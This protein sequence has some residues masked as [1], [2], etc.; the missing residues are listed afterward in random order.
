VKKL[1]FLTLLLSALF[2]QG[3]AE[4]KEYTYRDFQVSRE[5][6]Y[7]TMVGLLNEEGYEV[8][9]QS[10]NW[11]NDLPE[12]QMTTGWNMNQSGGIYKGND[13]RRKAYIR[14]ITS[15]TDRSGPEFQPLNEKDAAKHRKMTEDMK[16]RAKLEVTRVGVAVRMERRSDISRPFE[17][18]WIYEGPDGTSVTALLGKFELRVTDA[19]SEFGPS[20]KSE[21]LHE[22]E[23]RGK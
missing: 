15:V 17:S 22:G 3:C 2:M 20:K 10:E 6:A 18:D 12:V 21:K 14:V 8:V 23:M 13:V 7:D 19:T 9:E 5:I 16:K 11:V 1:L 4:Y